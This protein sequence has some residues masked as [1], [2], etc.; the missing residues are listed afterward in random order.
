MLSFRLRRLLWFPLFSVL[1]ECALSAQI[2]PVLIP[3]DPFEHVVDFEIVK[4]YGGKEPT[5]ERVFMQLPHSPASINPLVLAF[6]GAYFDRHWV[7]SGGG[8]QLAVALE[9]LMD[10]ATNRGWIV[11]SLEGGEAPDHANG[12][13]G[14]PETH[15]RISAVIDD[16][17]ELWGV[18]PDRIYTIGHSMGAADAASY[19]ARRQDPER[20]RVAA[21]FSWS[22]VLSTRDLVGDAYQRWF[23]ASAPPDQ[24]LGVGKLPYIASSVVQVLPSC[25]SGACNNPGSPLA[26][27]ALVFNLAQVPFKVTHADTDGCFATCAY[28]TAQSLAASTNELPYLFFDPSFNNNHLS[29][30]DFDAAAIC[31]FFEPEHLSALGRRMYKTVAVEDVRYFYFDVS[32]INPSGPGVF[33]WDMPRTQNKLV[34]TAPKDLIALRFSVDGGAPVSAP[35]VSTSALTIVCNNSVPTLAFT[36]ENFLTAPNTVFLNGSSAN[37]TDWE[38]DSVAKILKLKALHQNSTFIWVIS[39]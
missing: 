31:D 20:W 16:I 29:T 19:A 14:G 10:E 30:E 38:Y 33:G 39:P 23:W 8:T 9:E 26:D 24:P 18:D 11:A 1:A 21:V 28:A 35:L 25:L 4:R 32:L 34:L 15:Q 6:H 27:E 2:P 13:Y 5:S 7:G 12:T 3:T 17:D 37:T 22:G 36:L